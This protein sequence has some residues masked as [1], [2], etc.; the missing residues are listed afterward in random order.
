MRREVH[1][2]HA[3]RGREE[4]VE[5]QEGQADLQGEALSRE[6]GPTEVPCARAARVQNP[7]QV[8]REQGSGVVRECSPQGADGGEGRAELDQIRGG[9]V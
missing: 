3:L 9:P 2:V 4:V 7:V 8:A 5:V 1:G 6:G